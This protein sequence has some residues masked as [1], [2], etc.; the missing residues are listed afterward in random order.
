[1]MANRHY[2]RVARAVGG[3]SAGRGGRVD[4]GAMIDPLC[5]YRVAHW[6][7]ERRIGTI[8]KALSRLNYFL[9]GC[10]IAHQASIGRRVHV[11]HYGSGVVIHRHVKIGDDVWIM[12]QVVLGQNLREGNPATPQG[13]LIT[14][15]NGVLLGAG[16]KVIANG[17]L[18]IGDYATVGANAV[19]T[20]PVPAGALAIGVPAKILENR[21]PQL[22]GS[23]GG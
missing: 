20:K 1:M 8:P 9:T 17:P 18:E 4:W 2:A 6:L 19:V 12:P 15:G 16:A 5:L 23:R 7:W 13:M 10:D 3:V 11:Q 21:S 22:K 14:V